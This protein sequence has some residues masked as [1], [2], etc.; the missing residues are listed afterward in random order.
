MEEYVREQDKWSTEN[1][2]ERSMENTPEYIK[3]EAILEY[4][5]KPF[6]MQGVNYAPIDLNMNARQAYVK[7]RM[8]S[9]YK[10]NEH[11]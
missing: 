7:G 10:Q 5:I 9:I 8:V 1:M 3:N 11:V 4:P 6:Y 2:V